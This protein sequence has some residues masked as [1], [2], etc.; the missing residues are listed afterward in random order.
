M[1]PWNCRYRGH[2]WAIG[3]KARDRAIVEICANCGQT[4]EE[5]A[6]F[7]R[8]RVEEAI[9]EGGIGDMSGQAAPRTATA[10][11][12]YTG[13][14]G[15]HDN[16]FMELAEALREERVLERL[17]AARAGAMAAR[18]LLDKLTGPLGGPGSYPELI[19]ALGEALAK[20][21]G[22]GT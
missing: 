8:R 6:A 7:E 3:I 5:V 20:V 13:R 15:F 9:F 18:A 4:R 17:Q 22:E 2:I 10:L 12:G 11:A 16:E 1:T 14:S 21:E 19:A